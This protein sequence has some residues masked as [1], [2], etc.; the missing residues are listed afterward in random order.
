MPLKIW[1]SPLWFISNWIFFWSVLISRIIR[2]GKIHHSPGYPLYNFTG[3]SRPTP[4]SHDLIV[5]LR[6]KPNTETKPTIRDF[7][8]AE[9][10]VTF[11]PSSQNVQQKDSLELFVWVRPEEGLSSCPWNLQRAC[12]LAASVQLSKILVLDKQKCLVCKSVSK[13][14]NPPRT[15][16]L[17]NSYEAFELRRNDPEALCWS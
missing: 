17:K 7:F 14:P 12:R 2:L 1:L 13:T 6:S 5:F 16:A 4:I 11:G 3:I 8:Q 9:G 10:A 15:L